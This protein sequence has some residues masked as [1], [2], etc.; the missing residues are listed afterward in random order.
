MIDKFQD[1]LRLERNYSM[2]TVDEYGKDLRLRHHPRL[3]GEH[4][5]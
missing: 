3:D 4:D 5:R 1:Y 2:R